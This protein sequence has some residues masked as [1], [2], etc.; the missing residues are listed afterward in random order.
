MSVSVQ[1]GQTK[2]ANGITMIS[3]SLKSALGEQVILLMQIHAPAQE[4]KTVEKESKTIV[5]H[6]LLE[7][8]GEA[9]S[10]LDGT[11]KEINGFFKG[12]I[13]SQKVEDIHAIIAIIDN[14]NVL[15][16]SHAGR[17]EA[18]VVRGGGASQITEYTRGKPT[19]AFVH[20]ASG[21]LEA[22]D[23]LILSTQRLLRTFTPAQLVQL[24]QREDQLLTEVKV[25]LEAEKEMAALA[26]LEVDGS[27]STA[28]KPLA[29]KG[30]TN[31]RGRR[32]AQSA[33]IATILA[34]NLKSAGQRIQEA[35][36]ATDKLNAVKS[37]SASFLTDLKDPKKKRRSHFLLLAGILALFI[38]IWSVVNL[39]AYSK[40]SQTRAEL[41]QIIEEIEKDI[42]TA[43]NRYL[44]GEA[45]SANAILQRAE[46]RTKQ[47]MDNED[48][49]FREEAH[50]LL[51]QIR[52]KSEEINN[53]VRITPRTV[54]NIAAENPDV[55]TVGLIGLEDGEF[56]A[57]DHQD[58][59]R[60]LLN[61]VEAPERITDDELLLQGTFFDR[62]KTLVFQTNANSV[63]E[64]IADQPTSM[65]TEDAAGWING[66]SIHAY[67]RF[68]YVLSAENNQIYKYERFSNRY[69]APTQY[70][71]NGD[72]RNS[73]DMAID[74]NVYVLKEGGEV[75]KLFRGEV[76]QF[77]VRQLPEEALSTA[78]KVFKVLDGNL[79]FLDPIQS[80]VIVVTD[81]G[82]TGEASY[83]RQYVLEGD[84]GE[85]KDVYVDPDETLLYVL[86]EKQLYA[87]DLK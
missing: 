86:G 62:Y 8:E 20:I 23:S 54:V 73:V 71:V 11:L 57:Y 43:E 60:I 33:P 78:A 45:D 29:K 40:R 22:K 48:K 38:V 85:L 53:I 63:I 30:T 27:S 15:H 51:G 84:I 61:A 79:Y 26:T 5:K 1:T 82:E 83:V 74:G 66:V 35:F 81:G 65:K 2:S 19:P 70:N 68:L 7:T 34:E 49:V 75:V 6:S 18:Y 56:I 12:L 28:A 80:R 16:V 41:Q 39:S 14:D 47:V 21:G 9:T 24:A 87:V 13:V 10:R 3:E 37:K 25:A 31:R 59:Y 50:N 69:S 46:E 44:T 4:A 17:A 36:T 32:S 67:L 58:V 76:Q 42:Q 52:T 55:L 72:L 77:V 64:I